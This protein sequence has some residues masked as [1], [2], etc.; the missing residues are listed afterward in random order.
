MPVLP[1]NL[2]ASYPTPNV[3]YGLKNKPVP[4]IMENRRKL[5]LDVFMKYKII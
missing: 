1:R 5:R 4:A 3:P 2:P